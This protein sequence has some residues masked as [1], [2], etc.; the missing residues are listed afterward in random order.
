M[1][2]RY[3]ASSSYDRTIKIW[4]P[5]TGSLI[6]TLVGHSLYV[7]SL[8]T[9]KNGNLASSSADKTIKLW[10]GAPNWAS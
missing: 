4:D 2:S 1:H 9:L 5:S 8:E 10:G 6:Q 7:W 3:I